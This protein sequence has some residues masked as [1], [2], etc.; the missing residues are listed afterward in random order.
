M[1]TPTQ[2]KNRI[3]ELSWWLQNNPN[4]PNRVLIEKDKREAERELAEKEKAA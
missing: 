3:E 4:H 2:L 1:R